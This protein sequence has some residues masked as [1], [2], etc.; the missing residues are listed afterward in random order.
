MR[1][2][3]S[4]LIQLADMLP[5][6]LELDAGTLLDRMP[7]LLNHDNVELELELL[8]RDPSPDYPNGR[9]FAYIAPSRLDHEL[10][11]HHWY[12]QVDLQTGDIM[13]KPDNQHRAKLKAVLD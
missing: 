13:Y 11:D 6:E 9:R 2:L 8:W 3:N 12:Y 10:R 4:I 5:R 1:R 7:H